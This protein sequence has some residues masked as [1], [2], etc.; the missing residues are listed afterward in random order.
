[1]TEFIKPDFSN[2]NVDRSLPTV[3][4]S[5]VLGMLE[6][7]F[8]Q[9]GVAQKTHDKYFDDPASEYYRMSVKQIIDKFSMLAS[10]TLFHKIVSK[11]M[12]AANS[13]GHM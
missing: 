12:P 13:K 7:P 2:I 9:L 3:S 5:A 6:E 1:M 11:A 8:D 4:I 10:F